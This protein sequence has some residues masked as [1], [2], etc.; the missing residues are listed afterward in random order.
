MNLEFR[1]LKRTDA[2]EFSRWGKHQDPRFFQYNF[3][4]TQKAEFDAWYASKQRW[5][6]KKVYG[7]FIEDY[8]IGFITLKHIRWI[9]KRAE[10][11]V[12]VDPNHMSEGFGSEMIRRF[13]T[14]VFNQYPIETMRLRVAHFNKR[15]QK[16]YEKIGFI[17]VAEVVEPF[18]EQSFKDIVF[19]RYPDQFDLV[20]GVL[21]TH[22]YVMEIKKSD[23]MRTKI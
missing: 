11:G 1:K 4:Y 19:E 17:K 23:Y 12:A 8:P 16:S 13:L 20:D 3:P 21:Y 14:Y 5:L 18:E 2:Y 22:F 15:A 6:T 7:L 9:K 10:L